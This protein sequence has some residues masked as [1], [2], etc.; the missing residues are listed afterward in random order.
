[1]TAW[2]IIQTRPDSRQG[3]VWPRFVSK[4][5][6]FR[7]MPCMNGLVTYATKIKVCS[8]RQFVQYRPSLA[9]VCILQHQRG[10]KVL[11]IPL[12]YHEQAPR[13]WNVK[14]QV[15]LHCLCDI[16]AYQVSCELNILSSLHV[17]AAYKSLSVRR[18]DAFTAGSLS[19]KQ[20][21]GLWWLLVHRRKACHSGV[22][23]LSPFGAQ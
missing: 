9:C 16:P 8:N 22:H 2:R 5:Y 7:C 19:S 12:A 1:M 3:D 4:A 17:K 11:G 20:N 23:N 6:A 13:R 14:C 18:F 21:V 10:H 15:A